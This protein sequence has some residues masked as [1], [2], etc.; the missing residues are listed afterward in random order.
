MYWNILLVSFDV[1]IKNVYITVY[2][3]TTVAQYFKKIVILVCM[4]ILFLYQS[5]KINFEYI[6]MH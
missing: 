5:L 4:L 3:F 6:S 2:I 1:T